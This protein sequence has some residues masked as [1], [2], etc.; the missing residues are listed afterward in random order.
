[1]KTQ[2]L[3][4]AQQ[5]AW[6]RIQNHE[7]LNPDNAYRYNVYSPAEDWTKEF[8]HNGEV[9]GEKT[10]YANRVYGMFNSATLRALEKKG[11]IKVHEFGGSHY[12]DEIEIL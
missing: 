6:D 7:T 9:I 11:L 8:I 4:K 12:P 5:E 10:W 3:T 1:M 2:K